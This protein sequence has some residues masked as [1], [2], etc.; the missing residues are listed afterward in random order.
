MSDDKTLEIAVPIGTDKDGHPALLRIRGDETGPKSATMGVLSPL[1]EG[2]PLPPG[3]D[4]VNL[5]PCPSGQHMKCETV[6]ESPGGSRA[7]KP[8]SVSQEKFASNWDSIF[9]GDDLDAEPQ[10]EGELL[11]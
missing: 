5:K 4:L 8:M 9:G 11:N 3:A 7:W 10:S 2:Q 1:H 6:Y